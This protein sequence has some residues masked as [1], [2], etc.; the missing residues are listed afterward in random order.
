MENLVVYKNDMNTV[1]LRDFNSKEIY[2]FFSIC[3]QM[4]DKGLIKITFTFEQ[5]KD[6]SNYKFTTYE[7][8]SRYTENVYNK[9]IKLNIRIETQRKDSKIYFIY[10]I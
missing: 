2:L 9:L 10:K 4:R 5:L 7:K 3:S 6:L 1:P 8:F